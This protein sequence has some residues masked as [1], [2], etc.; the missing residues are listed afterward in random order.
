MDVLFAQSC[1]TLCDRM[2]CSPPDFSV[3][4]NL[5]ARILQWVAIDFSRDL[6]YTRIEPRSPVLQANSLPLSHLGSQ[7]K[8]MC[9]CAGL[10][11]R[12]QLFATLWTVTCQASLSM[13]FSRQEYWSGLSFP[14][15][16]DLPD[17]G[18]EPGSPALQ[19]DSFLSYQESP[20]LVEVYFF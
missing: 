10:S 2:D 8:R 3:H 12:V 18:I 5:Q 14:S 7:I 11:S 4:G 6:P 1:L 20:I 13:G 19:A 9:A 15:P 16:G 17:S